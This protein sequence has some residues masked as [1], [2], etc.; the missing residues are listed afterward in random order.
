VRGRATLGRPWLNWAAPRVSAVPGMLPG[1][2]P[3]LPVTSLRRKA[4]SRGPPCSNPRQGPRAAIRHK[5]R[6]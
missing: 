5:G 3:P 1:S 2:S 4:R 6:V